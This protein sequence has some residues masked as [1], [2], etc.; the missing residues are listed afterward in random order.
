MG[1]R[2]KGPLDLVMISKVN[3][4]QVVSVECWED[5]EGKDLS[6][7]GQEKWEKE[8]QE[9][10]A[11]S[12]EVLLKGKKT[13]GAPAGRGQ[14]S[15]EGFCTEDNQNVSVLIKDAIERGLKLMMQ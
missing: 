13:I 5:A 1:T 7:V 15:Q 12:Q 2:K 6:G 9:S 10:L 11:H 8:T 14:E 4:T 3:L